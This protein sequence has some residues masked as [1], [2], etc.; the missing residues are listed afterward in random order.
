MTVAPPEGSLADRDFPALVKRLYESEWTGNVMLTHMGVRKG[1]VF[2][3]GRTDGTPRRRPA[4]RLA[5]IEE[6]SQ[7]DPINVLPPDKVR[8]SRECQ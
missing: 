6:K 4:H 5:S 7:P 3:A 1:V 2:Q 8:R